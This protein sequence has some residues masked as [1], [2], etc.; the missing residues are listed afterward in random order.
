M[1]ILKLIGLFMWG[2]FIVGFSYMYGR[3]VDGFLMKEAV[4]MMFILILLPVGLF[5]FLV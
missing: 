1:I 3:L 5:F 4:I 2:I